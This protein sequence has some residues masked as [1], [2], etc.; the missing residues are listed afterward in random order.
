MVKFTVLL[1]CHGLH[2]LN[3]YSETLQLSRLVQLRY[4]LIYK[5]QKT[6]VA[7]GECV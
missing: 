5:F 6:F 3:Y 4:L 2:P 1:N 7:L